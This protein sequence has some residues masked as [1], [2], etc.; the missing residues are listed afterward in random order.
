MTIF[1][2]F[3]QEN[4]KRILENKST[5]QQIIL[6]N[7]KMYVVQK[8]LKTNI[9]QTQQKNTESQSQCYFEKE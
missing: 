5:N 3:T 7:T 1:S 2:M 4:N 9:Q 6:M 8:Y